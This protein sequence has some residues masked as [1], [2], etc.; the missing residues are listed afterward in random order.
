MEGEARFA[1]LSTF[2]CR[3]NPIRSRILRSVSVK[4]HLGL[5]GLGSSVAAMQPERTGTGGAKAQE[6]KRHPDQSTSPPTEPTHPDHPASPLLEKEVATRIPDTV[7][8]NQ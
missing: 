7:S 1:L 2:P 4:G 5:F 8:L 6:N 3:G